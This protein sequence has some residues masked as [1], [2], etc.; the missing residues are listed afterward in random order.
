MAKSSNKNNLARDHEVLPP[1]VLKGH[2]VYYL[3]EKYKKKLNLW[4]KVINVAKEGRSVHYV[5][6]EDAVSSQMLKIRTC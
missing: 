2:F 5:N 3:Y 4:P 1:M 6:K